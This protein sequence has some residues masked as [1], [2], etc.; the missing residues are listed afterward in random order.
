MATTAA[1]PSIRA[2]ARASL[3]HVRRLATVANANA[4]SSTASS[5]SISASSSASSSAAL[6]SSSGW[7]PP[8]TPGVEPAYDEA[9]AYIS[10]QQAS[11]RREIP[12]LEAAISSHPPGS[13]ERSSAQAKLDAHLVAAEINDPAVRWRFANNVDAPLSSPVFAHLREQAWRRGPLERLAAR[14][15]DMYVVPDVLLTF[16]PTVDVRVS[17]GEGTGFTD[18]TSKSGIEDVSGEI[19]D[20]GCII[21]AA[22]TFDRPSI[23]ATPFHA[24]ERLYTLALVDADA[25]YEAEERI[26]TY[27]HW[28]VSDIALSSTKNTVEGGSDLVSYI[29]PHPQKGTKPHRYALCLLAQPKGASISF[30]SVE[31]RQFSLRDF[32]AQNNLTVEGAHFWRSKWTEGS[33]STITDVYRQFLGGEENEPH[34]IRERLAFKRAA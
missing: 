15:R 5:S 25:P 2:Q 8:I 6:S 32:A 20:P 3:R 10:T 16:T 31:R 9:L 27:L 21:P 17:F 33:S 1:I 4:S 11:L 28:L 7:T 18:V 14:L 34:F 12:A 13:S 22:R 29:P 30:S 23:L 26:G 24:E 19:I